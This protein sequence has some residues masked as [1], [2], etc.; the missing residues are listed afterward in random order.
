MLV[1]L[2]GKN[3]NYANEMGSGDMICVPSLMKISTGVKGILGFCFIILKG[4]N[5]DNTVGRDL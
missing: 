3:M 5:V 4:C 2:T 1:L